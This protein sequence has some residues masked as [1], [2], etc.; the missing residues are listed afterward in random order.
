MLWNATVDRITSMSVFKRAV[1]EGSLAAAARHFGISPEMAGAHVRS[2]ETR[3][4]ARLLNRTTRRLHLTEVG[5]SYYARCASI[6]ADIEEAE[7]EASSQQAA[8]RGLLRIAAPLTF[9]VRHMASAVSDYVASHPEVRVEVVLSDRFVNLIEEGIDLA[10][11]VGDLQESSLIA[12][13][14]ASAHLVVCAAPEYL[15][16]AGEPETPSD[17]KRHACLIYTET[18]APTKWRFEG[19]NGHVE[20][21]NV[22]GTISS[23]S[24]EFIHQLALAG[25]GVMLAPSF[26]VGMDI[27]QE[28]LTALL[29]DWRSRALPI[30]ILYPHRP[31]LSAKVRT[32]VD[33]LAG[34][35][36]P[37]P[38]WERWSQGSYVLSS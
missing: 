20:T 22:S 16:R 30:H 18:L 12:R 23:S 29:T 26:A 5:A 13:R 4:G 15:R 9:G 21:V 3:L 32:F 35:F 7:A 8:P 38:E 27:A 6:L 36:G 19:A 31:L 11:R 24:V 37:T 14:L 17:L 1:D 34:R 10:I 2:L 33:F 25:H 28:R